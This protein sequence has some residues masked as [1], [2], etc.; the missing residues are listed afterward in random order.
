MHCSHEATL[1]ILH[2]KLNVVHTKPNGSR[3]QIVNINNHLA[4]VNC[5]QSFSFNLCLT[6]VSK[7]SAVIPAGDGLYLGLYFRGLESH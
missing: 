1:V 6:A 2:A 5:Q 3:N 4:G 7:V